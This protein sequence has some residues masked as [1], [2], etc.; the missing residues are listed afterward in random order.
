MPNYDYECT[1]GELKEVSHRM[2]EAPDVKCDKCDSKMEKIIS[3]IAGLEFKGSGFY[4]TDYK[5]KGL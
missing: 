2:A 1:C 4:K 5:D 3:G